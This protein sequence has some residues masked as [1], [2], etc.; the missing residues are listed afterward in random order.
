[1]DGVETDA[2]IL[3]RR[4]RLTESSLIVTWLTERHGKLKTVA[5]GARRPRSAF[6]G[7]LDL[8]FA[9]ELT[10]SRSRR[11]ELHALREVSLTDPREGLR[12]IYPRTQLAAYFVEL[13]DLTTE[14][15]HPAPEIFDLLRRGLDY[16]CAHRPDRRALLHFETQLSHLLGVTGLHNSAEDSAQAIRQQAGRLPE[17]RAALLLSLPADK[18]PMTN[19]PPQP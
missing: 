17:G 11:S 12:Q 13:I 5:K 9:A 6:A 2:A 19:P 16:L 10:F 3:L 14:L 8:F 15:E 1:M 7:L 4:V 18:N